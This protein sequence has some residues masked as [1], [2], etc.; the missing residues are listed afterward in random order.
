MAVQKQLIGIGFYEVSSCHSDT[1]RICFWSICILDVAALLAT[2]HQM[3]VAVPNFFTNWEFITISFF[4][5]LFFN[6]FLRI[7]F[8]SSNGAYWRKPHKF[9]SYILHWRNVWLLKKFMKNKS[10]CVLY[11]DVSLIYKF[12]FCHFLCFRFVALFE[13]HH[14]MT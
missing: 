7:S 14:I 5:S 10:R 3:L 8:F 6:N 12:V 4:F 11:L 2:E 1:G 13:T 9:S